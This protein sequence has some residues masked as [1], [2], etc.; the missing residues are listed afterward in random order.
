[1]KGEKACLFGQ[2]LANR[3]VTTNSAR[4]PVPCSMAR[5]PVFAPSGGHLMACRD[6]WP[7]RAPRAWARHSNR[8]YRI[9]HRDCPLPEPLSYCAVHRLLDR[10]GV[11]GLASRRRMIRTPESTKLTI[12]TPRHWRLA[13]PA[14]CHEDLRYGPQRFFQ[15]RLVK[16]APHAAA[17]SGPVGSVFL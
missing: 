15:V 13:D 17:N 6:I 5:V 16:G 3:L 12:P 14:A 2:S 4:P 11:R 1:M 9:R 7:C 8:A 10:P